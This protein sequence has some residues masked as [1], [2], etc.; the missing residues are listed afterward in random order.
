MGTFYFINIDI[1]F[2]IQGVPQNSSIKSFH[3]EEVERKF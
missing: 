3:V 1:I 2:V